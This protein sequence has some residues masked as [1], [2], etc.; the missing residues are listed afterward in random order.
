[1]TDALIVADD[2]PLDRPRFIYDQAAVRIA[3]DTWAAATSDPDSR[4]LLDLC[5][6]KTRVVLAF[7]EHIR[8]H[9]AAVTPAGVQAWQRELRRRG[10]AESTIYQHASFLSSFYRWALSEPSLARDIRANP[11]TLA[12]PKAPKPYQS[13]QTKS[14]SDD[15]AVPVCGG[16]WS[17]HER[18]AGGGADW[19][20]RLCLA[21]AVSVH[22][23]AAARDHSAVLG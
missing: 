9:P 1:M 4:R 10:L 8:Q 5:R 22:W 19:Q 3:V 11:V 23:P 15:E 20:A 7:F 14:L 16:A 13:N 2:A 12:R 18:R 21:A 17:R 6:D